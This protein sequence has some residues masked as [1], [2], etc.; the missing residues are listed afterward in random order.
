M[1]LAMQPLTHPEQ[2]TQL[3]TRLRWHINT[4]TKDAMFA[5]DALIRGTLESQRAEPEIVGKTPKA[6]ATPTT[7]QAATTLAPLT[8]PAGH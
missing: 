4:R 6:A 7:T 8:N 5:N 1:S 3:M 2:Q